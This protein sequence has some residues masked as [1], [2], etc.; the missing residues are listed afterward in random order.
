MRNPPEVREQMFKLIEQ[1]QQ[2]GVTQNAFCQQQSIRYHVFHYWY[3]RYRGQHGGPQ[4]NA[5]SFVKLQVAKPVFS[6]SVEIY[7]PGGIR[8]VFHEPVS[9]NYLKALIS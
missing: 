3:K 6:G 5:A 7:Y 8:L 4:S 1:W 9:S 2:S